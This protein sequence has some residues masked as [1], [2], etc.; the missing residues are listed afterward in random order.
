YDQY[1]QGDSNALTTAQRLG[2][3]LFRGKAG[4][5]VCHLGPNLTDERYH[6]TGVG[7][8]A[9]Q[10]RF[11]VTKL[12]S[13]HGAFKTP[14][15]R[16]VARTPPYMHDGSLKSLEEVIDFYDKG[17]KKNPALDPEIHELQLTAEEKTA[18][19]AFLKALN[20]TVRDGM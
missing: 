6:N 15:L 19:L 10:G 7:W 17:G 5:A 16:E 8:P 20:G 9:D 4:C 1:L 14:S 2:L 11:A 18:L 13:D 12:A 3:R